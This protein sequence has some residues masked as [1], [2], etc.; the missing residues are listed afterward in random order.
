MSTPR[1]DN[2]ARYSIPQVCEI[3]GLKRSTV[4]ARITAGLLR[5]VKDG[6]RVFIPR[7]ELDR[8][9]AACRPAR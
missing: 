4:Y 1:N 5:P 3:I 7:D 9:L 8:Y 6:A 2:A